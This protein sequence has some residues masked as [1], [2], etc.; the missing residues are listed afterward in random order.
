MFSANFKK[1][2]CNFVEKSKMEAKLA[3]ILGKRLL[4]F[5]EI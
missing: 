1:I 2:C 4:L 5:I 3:G